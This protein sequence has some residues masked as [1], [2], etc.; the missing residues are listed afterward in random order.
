MITSYS[1]HLIKETEIIVFMF[2][3][4]YLEVLLALGPFCKEPLNAVLQGVTHSD[5]DVSVDKIKTAALPVLLKFI[6]VDDGLELK[7]VRR[8][9]FVF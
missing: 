9:E 6:L 2:S 3:G 5:L 8:G 1:K 7:I 4:Y